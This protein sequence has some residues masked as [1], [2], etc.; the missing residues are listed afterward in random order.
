MVERDAHGRFLHGNKAAVGHG[1]PKKLTQVSTQDF[2][3]TVIQMSRVFNIYSRLENAR[4]PRCKI[5]GAEHFTWTFKPSGDV[6]GNCLTL[7]CPGKYHL[8]AEYTPDE[9]LF[10]QQLHK[11]QALKQFQKHEKFR[12]DMEKAKKPQKQ[13]LECGYWKF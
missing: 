5:E 11:R 10:L 2:T 7:G 6:F 13:N 4:C 8:K 1:R 9:R 12:L 3:L